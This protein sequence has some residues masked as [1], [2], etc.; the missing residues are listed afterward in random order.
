ML[1]VQ[2][3]EFMFTGDGYY[4]HHEPSRFLANLP[5]VTVVDCHITHRYLWPLAKLCDVLILPI[6]VGWE[7][8]PLIE[9]RRRE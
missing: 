8:F 1:I 7:F 6:V 4:R 3:C 2:A 9:E 5:G